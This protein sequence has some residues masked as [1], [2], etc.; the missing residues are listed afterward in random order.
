VTQRRREIGLRAALGAHPRRILAAIFSRAARQLGIGAAIGLAMAL[1]LNHLS[2]GE[3][4]GGQARVVLPAVIAIILVV[5]LLATL[6]PARRGLRIQ[7]MEA[8]KADA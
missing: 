7:P 1:A 6:G 4:T 3:T 5:G 2:Q 8:L